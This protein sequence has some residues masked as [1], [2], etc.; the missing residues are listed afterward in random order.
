MMSRKS[1]FVIALLLMGLLLVPV[2]ALA[3]SGV[4][5]GNPDFTKTDA[6]EEGYWYSRYNLGN[7]VMRSGLGE[8]FMPDPAMIQ[9]MI[10]MVDAD[11]ERPGR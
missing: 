3:G 5:G 7:L 11:R 6:E 9:K 8:T 10:Q 2:I 4:T 1:T